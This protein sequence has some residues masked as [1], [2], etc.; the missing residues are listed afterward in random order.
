MYCLLEIVFTY[1][2]EKEKTEEEI[3]IARESLLVAW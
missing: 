2:K 1:L 3:N